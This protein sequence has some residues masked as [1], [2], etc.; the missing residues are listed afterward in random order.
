MKSLGAI[1]RDPADLP[2]IDNFL[3]GEALE[4]EKILLCIT[5][6]CLV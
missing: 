3:S 6:L 1:I 5:I 2:N 4:A